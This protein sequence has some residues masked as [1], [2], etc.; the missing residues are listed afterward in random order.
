MLAVHTPS[1]LYSEIAASPYP[2]ALLL[3]LTDACNLRCRMC[4]YWGESG[5]YTSAEPGRVRARPRS[6]DLDLA[7]RLIDELRPGRPV[8]SLFG[9]EPLLYPQLAEVIAAIKRAGSVVSLV[10]NGQELA[11]LAPMLVEQGL[12]ALR[13][14]LDGPRHINDPQ[15]GAGSFDRAMAGLEAV[16]HERTRQHKRR[17]GLGIAYAVTLD[18]AEH[19]Q[20]F[21]HR[22]VDV[23]LLEHIGI[24]LYIH[25]SPRNGEAFQTMLEDEWGLPGH[26]HWRALVREPDFL[27]AL[28]V[29]GL[30]RQIHS[31]RALF[32]RS[33]HGVF[34]TS[35]RITS[36]ANLRAHIADERERLSER[37]DFCAAP[38][39]TLQVTARGE[40]LPCMGATD[41]AFGD[42]HAQSFL[43]IWHGPL[44]E[45]LRARLFDR[46]LMPHCGACCM[47]PRLGHWRRPQR[48]LS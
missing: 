2:S 10:T 26:Q 21:F 22:E 39:T 47:L 29:D 12:D 5:L 37:Y 20:G 46:G 18:N 23:S 13:I 1:R 45:Q 43:E 28:D 15:R 4:L 31:V 19:L 11:A 30:S 41:F 24:N 48:R 8:Y 14:S 3:D 17:P 42:L 35:P 32:A 44:Y 36:P 9:G 40:V 27:D 16:L 34:E 7:L 6:L 33:G 38:W 25:M